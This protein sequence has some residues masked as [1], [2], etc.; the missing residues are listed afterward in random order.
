MKW[1]KSSHLE[2]FKEHL[3]QILSKD[4][5]SIRGQAGEMYSYFGVEKFIGEGHHLGYRQ[6]FLMEDDLILKCIISKYHYTPADDTKFQ[7]IIDSFEI[8]RK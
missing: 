1:N 7:K 4:T 3:P 6:F 8:I 5:I 2:S